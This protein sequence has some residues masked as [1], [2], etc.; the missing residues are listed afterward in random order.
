[1]D[2]ALLS[3]TNF[4]I[5]EA[6]NSNTFADNKKREFKHKNTLLYTGHNR[7]IFL[8]NKQVEE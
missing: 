6:I 8:I 5:L 1:M 7:F 2:D 3:R 4:S